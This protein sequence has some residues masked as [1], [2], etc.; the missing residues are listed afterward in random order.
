MAR[1]IPVIYQQLLAQKNA[2]ANLASLNSNSQVS[3]WNLWLWIVATG[4]SLFEQLCDQFQVTLTTI[5]TNAPVF[6]APWYSAMLKYFQYSATNPQIVAQDPTTFAVSYANVNASLNIITQNA[7][8]NTSNGLVTLKVASNST[9]IETAFPGSTAALKSFLSA[10]GIPGTQFVIISQT[11]DHA[12]C[13]CTVYYDASYSGVIA[14]NLQTAYNN[15][16]S[17]IPFNGTFEVSDLE[18]ALKAVTGVK[19]VVIGTLYVKVA[20]DGYTGIN[21]LMQTIAG[22]PTIINRL[23]AT[24]AGYAIDDPVSTFTSGLTLIAQ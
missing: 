6:S 19:D 9:P 17:A 15:F 12:T 3:I 4:Q 5:V 1:S 2:Q 8:I 20:N 7:V 21:Y 13:A 10:I 11:P 16:L 18:A 14:A 24:E 23:W 22:N